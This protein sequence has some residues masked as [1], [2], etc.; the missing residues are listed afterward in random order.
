MSTIPNPQLSGRLSEQ[1]IEQ[2][3]RQ[4]NRLFEEVTHLA[5][6]DM[7][8]AG[9][10]A[11]FLQRV[12]LG[13]AAPAGALWIRT[14]QGNLQLQHQA[15]L[16]T[17]GL[18]RSE[19]GR[20]SHDELLRQT[21][22]TGKPQIIPPNSSSGG[23]AGSTSGPGN[24]TD[25]VVLLAPIVIEKEV[26]GLIEIWQ[27]A[28]HSSEAMPGFLQFMIRM[29]GLASVFIRNTQLRRMVGQQQVWTQLETFARQV[30]S[31]LNPTEV[32]YII[33]N[34][35][36]RLLACDRVSVAVRHS[37]KMKI[38]SISGAD[39]VE[40]RSSLVQL[41]R[42]LAEKVA[43]WGDRLVYQGT[44]DDSLPP[45][46]LTALDA[47]L[48][49]S[50]A[51]MVI[52]QPL[53]DERE[54]ESKKPIRS[55]LILESFEPGLSIEQLQAR[56]EVVSRHATPALYNA[57]EY[58]RIPMRFLWMPLVKLQDG[59]GGKGRAIAAGVGAAVLL[60]LVL[61]VFVPYPL[62]MDATGQ[63]LPQVRFWIYSESPDATVV[64]IPDYVQ[65][66]KTVPQGGDLIK[67]RDQKLELRLGELTADVRSLE[68]EI[69]LLKTQHGNAQ[70]AQRYDIE[71]LLG[72]KVQLKERKEAEKKSLM[73]RYNMRESDPGFI[74]ITAPV[75]GTIINSNFRE[76]L[77]GRTVKPSEQLLRIG[78][79]AKGWEI[80]LRI[81][82]RHIGQVLLAFEGKP[83]DYELDV[84]LLLASAPT[85][86]YKGKLLRS[87]IYPEANPDKD[88]PN[89]TEPI[90][91]ASVRIDGDGIPEENTL[92]KELLV[93]GT[94]VHAKIRCGNRA[95]GY[96][97]FYGV[98]E[99]I[100]EKVLFYVF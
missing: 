92:P 88:N 2:I 57:V 8:P 89:N 35:A 72:E 27:D 11:E 10:Y 79:K 70:Q 94:E 7:E 78:D 74:W 68:G 82:Q 61:F 91:I 86:T 63:L 48:A 93:T 77:T 38:E 69:V 45:A 87:R 56:L 6:Q 64:H 51:K 24:P 83:E 5:E 25:F 40:K 67:M 33:A 47:Y 36:R 19:E 46:V 62:K 84:D 80:E 20:K 41:Q 1:K 98:W 71:R 31:S 28:R 23:A 15:N 42:T 58:R 95:M 52:V 54:K 85:Q 76:N 16:Q 29:A 21:C 97:L 17:V 44:K 13:V 18:D 99:F 3:R 75:D 50:N 55:A 65:T 9:F 4:I 96:S 60:L 49:E 30:H 90:V 100:Y 59:L 53:R 37:V 81:P 14:A 22:Q 26:A 34:E 73:Q 66:G 43:D 12:L 39:V 32:A